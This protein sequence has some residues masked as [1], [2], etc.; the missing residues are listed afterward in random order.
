MD[1][2]N[3]LKS[4]AGAAIGA[5]GFPYIVPSRVLGKNGQILPN[6]KINLG[7]IGVGS[8]GTGH[9][10]SFVGYE[11]VQITAICDVRREHRDRAKEIVDQRYNNNDCYTY[12]DYRELLAR[13]DIDA[14]VIAVPD[15]WHALIGIEAARRGKDMYYEKAMGFSINETKALRKAVQDYN[16]VFQFG[17]QQRSDTRFRLACELVWNG[18]IGQLQT[19]T[20]GSASF[21]PIPDQPVQPVPEGFDYDF[22]L[23]SAV[24]APYTFERC[25]RNWTLIRDYSLGCVGS[26]WGVHPVDIAQLASGMENTCPVTVEAK[27]EFPSEGL[28]DT[29]RHWRAEHTYSNGV[30]LIHMDR[31]TAMKT[32]DQFNL[33]W[34]GTLFSGT[35]G[36]IFVCRQLMKTFPESLV[37]TKFSPNDLRMPISNNH[38]RNFL[39]AVRTR[40]RTMSPVE[41]GAQADFVCHHED[42]AMR[43]GRKLYWDPV[44]E[45]FINDAEA[46]RL[47][48][49]PLRSPWHL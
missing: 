25:T 5:F 8:M 40:Q 39:D 43:L 11:D 6:D 46:N 15:Q 33:H 38:H 32:V 26:A 12:N 16:I 35:E 14:V 10:H 48:E 18:K 45:E 22:W 31:P 9:V 47:M 13:K 27:G 42:I 2:R 49:R 17:T 28:Y 37:R 1:R 30:K 24:W 4:S 41:S 36:W 21:E 7:F 44:K 19:I 23:G 3:F 34:E 20:I 29:A